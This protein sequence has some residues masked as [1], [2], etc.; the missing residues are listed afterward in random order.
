MIVYNKS[1]IFYIKLRTVIHYFNKN[2]FLYLKNDNKIKCN[3]MN[4]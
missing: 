1:M 2:K 4:F 3:I